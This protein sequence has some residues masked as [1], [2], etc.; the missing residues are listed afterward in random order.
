M[1]AEIIRQRVDSTGVSEAEIN[2]S[3]SNIIVSIPGT[4]SAEQLKQIESSAMR[5]ARSR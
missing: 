3:G 4:P 5:I 1:R 2:T